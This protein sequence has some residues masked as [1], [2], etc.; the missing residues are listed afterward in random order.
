MK[1]FIDIGYRGAID[2]SSISYLSELSY[3]IIAVEGINDIRKLGRVILIPRYTQTSNSLKRG[4]ENKKKVKI[5]KVS[6][7][8]EVK[9]RHTL[10]RFHGIEISGHCVERLSIKVVKKLAKLKIPILLDMA[11]VLSN[12]MLGRKLHGVLNLLREFQKGELALGVIS[13]ATS[14]AEAMHPIIYE[15]LL[16]DLG[17][18]EDK[19]YEAV[20]VEPRRIVRRVGYEL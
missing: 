9:I 4:D 15:A 10:R 11:S 6:S 18:T 5:F 17:V 13:G 20:F 2:D 19:A 1:T 16:I 7:Q 3:R 14:P 12:L 8:D